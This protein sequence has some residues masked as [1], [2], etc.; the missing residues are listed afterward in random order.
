LRIPIGDWHAYAL[1]LE[2][3]DM[4]FFDAR[5]AS[6]L[7]IDEIVARPVL[8]RLAVH[9]SAYNT[10][11]WPK[12]GSVSVPERLRGGVPRFRQDPINGRLDISDDG[13]TTF[14]AETLDE[15]RGLECL[16]VWEP[17]HVEDRLR[18]H[19]AGVPNK[20]VESL[21]PRGGHA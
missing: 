19:Y 4:A 12:V 5:S 20:W 3:V 16:A 8:F 17:E 9:K 1:M 7:P 18:D 11:R 6:D 14:R 21:R 2:S 13:G 10:G 15:C